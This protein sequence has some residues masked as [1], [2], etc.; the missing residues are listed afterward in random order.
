MRSATTQK[1]PVTANQ[2]GG[3]DIVP[4]PQRFYEPSAQ[5]VAPL[6]LGH[7]L[8]RRTPQGLFGG[9]IVETEAYLADDPACHSYVGRT[10]RNRVMWGAPGFAYIYLIYGYHFCVNAVCCAEE[11]A[12]AVLIRAIEPIFGEALLRQNRPTESLRDL[13]NGPAKLCQAMDIDRKLDGESLCDS[14]SRLFIVENPDVG[15]FREERAPQITGK[16]IGISKAA[17]LPLRFFLAGSPFVSRGSIHRRSAK[18][19]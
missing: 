5:V 7:W 10:A 9:P 17:D 19:S 12:E 14:D 1:E 18:E 13:T 16:R 3:A 2:I 15:K 4:L 8:L 11:I 6:L